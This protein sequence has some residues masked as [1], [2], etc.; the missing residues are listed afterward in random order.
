MNNYLGVGCDAGVALNFH[1]QRESRPQLFQSR[2]INKVQPQYFIIHTHT[3]TA[4]THAHTLSLIIIPPVSPFYLFPTISLSFLY[5]HP[6]L[7]SSFLLFTLGMVSGVWCKGR[8]GAVMQ[9]PSPKDRGDP[10]PIIGG[11]ITPVHSLK[12]S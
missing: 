6:L 10:I 7:S 8:V 1:R 2:F 5:L 9:E 11:L 4:R 12:L 3:C